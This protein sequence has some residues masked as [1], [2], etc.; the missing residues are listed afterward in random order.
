[1]ENKYFK[2]KFGAFCKKY[3]DLINILITQLYLDVVP[4]L[5]WWDKDF[6]AISTDTNTLRFILKFTGNMCV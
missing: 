1:M 4:D 2:T 5:K 3:N 6:D